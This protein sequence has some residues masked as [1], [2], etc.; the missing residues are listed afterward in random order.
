MFMVKLFIHHSNFCELSPWIRT[1]TEGYSPSGLGHCHFLHCHIVTGISFEIALI[2]LIF[3]ITK[4]PVDYHLMRPLLIIVNVQDIFDRK[5][6]WEPF[7]LSFY[8]WHL[9]CRCFS[10]SLSPATLRTIAIVFIIVARLSIGHP[11]CKL[12]L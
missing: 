2:L 9:F 4:T 3:S 7:P 10:Y 5:I 12:Q 6:F 1:S 11:P 8:F